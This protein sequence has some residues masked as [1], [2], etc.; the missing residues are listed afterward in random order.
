MQN[1]REKLMNEAKFKL[2]RK[3]KNKL[4]NV[5]AEWLF[6]SELPALK[7]SEISKYRLFKMFSFVFY[8]CLFM[9]FSSLIQTLPT[10]RCLQLRNARFSN[11]L[12][13][14]TLCYWKSQ[15]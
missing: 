14:V 6:N 12:F 1:L 3:R 2:I 15:C 5:M 4:T 11:L 8:H 9:R 7:E 13:D 10:S